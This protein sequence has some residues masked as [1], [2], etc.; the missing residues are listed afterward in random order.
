[1]AP[2]PRQPPALMDEMVEE[3]LLRFAS[4]VPPSC[5]S[6]GVASSPTRASAA[7]SARP[8]D[9]HYGCKRGGSSGVV[10]AVLREYAG[11]PRVG[12][13]RRRTTR[14]IRWATRDASV[15]FDPDVVDGEGVKGWKHVA[16][17]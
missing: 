4:S 11:N 5:A 2:P 8:T 12:S 17:S 13:R 10:V 3:I 6:A 15:A 1:M 16:L 14:K 9:P 7:G